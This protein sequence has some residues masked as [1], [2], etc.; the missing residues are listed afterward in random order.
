MIDLLQDVSRETIDRLR[1]F[2]DIVVKWTPKINLVSR[3]DRSVVWDRHILDSMQMYSLAP[4]G[5][6]RWVDFG[7]GGGFPGVVVAILSEASKTPSTVT[8]IESDSRKAAFLR[9]ALRETGARATVIN[10]RIEQVRPQNAD[11]V[12]ARALADLAS[13]L[14]LAKPHMNAD[15]T[16]IFAK[17]AK[18]RTELSEAE[19]KWKFNHAVATSNLDPDA[20]ILSIRE[21][22]RA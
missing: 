12:S 11:V 5:F 13:L 1:S 3:Q 10:D 9:A 8:M 22:S 18:W 15:A 4:K 6:S 16:C 7:S 19:T 17:G 21:L 14:Q 2:E 20:A